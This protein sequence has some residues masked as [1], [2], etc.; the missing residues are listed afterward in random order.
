L[1]AGDSLRK[2]KEKE[3]E[4]KKKKKTTK[5]NFYWVIG[6]DIRDKLPEREKDN[7]K[8]K[9]VEGGKNNLKGLQEGR[10]SGD[11][12]KGGNPREDGPCY[13]ASPSIIAIFEKGD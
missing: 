1:T 9:E 11:L 7:P 8:R 6:K 13:Q 2:G 10:K 12:S 4:R 5:R 3:N